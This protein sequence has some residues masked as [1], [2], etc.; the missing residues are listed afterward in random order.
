MRLKRNY[1]QIL[2]KVCTNKNA[3]QTVKD[4]CKLHTKSCT[5]NFKQQTVKYCLQTVNAVTYQPYAV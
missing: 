3:H 4:L 5:S 1:I 2:V